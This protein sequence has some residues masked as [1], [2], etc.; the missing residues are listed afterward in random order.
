[1]ERN[2]NEIPN[3][4]NEDN[5]LK[6]EPL[7]GAA[8]IRVVNKDGEAKLESSI[9]IHEDCKE[10]SLSESLIGTNL[11]DL[12]RK[13]EEIFNKSGLK[14]NEYCISVSSGLIEEIISQNCN[15]VKTEMINTINSYKNDLE[16]TGKIL[17]LTD[18]QKTF[19]NAG[20]KASDI[21]ISKLKGEG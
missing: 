10:F 18:D 20:K 12:I 2:N 8:V 7:L 6:Y 14:S 9:F 17:E 13:S 4:T 3:N 11:P 19:I 15:A 16:N 1:M 5:Q 21:I